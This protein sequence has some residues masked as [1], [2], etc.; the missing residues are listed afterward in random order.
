MPRLVDVDM[1]PVRHAVHGDRLV[2]VR[3]AHEV[4]IVAIVGGYHRRHGVSLGLE[5]HAPSAVGVHGTVYGRRGA[6][7][8]HER[9]AVWRL[10]WCLAAVSL[11]LALALRFVLRHL[12]LILLL[13]VFILPS[14]LLLHGCRYALAEGNLAL[15]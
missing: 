12:L 13:L 7:A 3:L 9:V 5:H 15:R 10:L 8:R 14:H 4:G 2:V 6:V 1:N 11:R